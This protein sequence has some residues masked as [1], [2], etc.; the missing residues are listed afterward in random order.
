MESLP[1]TENYQGKIN[2][3]AQNI[4]DISDLHSEMTDATLIVCKI[5]VPGEN[6]ENVLKEDSENSD[7]LLLSYSADLLDNNMSDKGFHIIMLY[8]SLFSVFPY[9]L[10]ISSIRFGLILPLM[11]SI[12]S[13]PHLLFIVLIFLM[14]LTISSSSS[15]IST[16][17]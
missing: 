2:I 14:P 8:Y 11:V 16:C 15:I 3:L 10:I 1:K 17:T 6:V 5:I 7:I 9:T 12:E 13:P 4:K